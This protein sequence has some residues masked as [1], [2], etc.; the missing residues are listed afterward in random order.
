MSDA[1]ITLTDDN[2][3]TT[4]D[5]NDKDSAEISISGPSA[6]FAEGSDATFTVT[7]SVG[8]ASEVQVAWSAPLGTD[9]AEGA[10][11]SAT[12][13]T[14]TFAANSSAGATQSITITATD[15]AL[16][17]TVESFTVTLGTITST[18]SSQLSLKSG[19]SSATATISASDPITVSISGP[20]GE[21]T[22]GGAGTYTVSLS[23]VAPTADLTVSY[24]TADGTAISG[25]D[26]TAKSGTLTFTQTDAGDKT[27]TVRTIDDILAENSEDFTVSIS[28]PTG[29]GGPAPS[30]DTSK[31]TVTTTIRDNDALLLSPSDPSG[32]IDIQLS[33]API[34]VNEGAGETPFT[35]TATL[36]TGTPRTEDTTISLILGGTAGS[37]D[38]TAPAQ[39][40]VTISAN[41]PSG[42]GTLT[43]T[44]IDDD[45]SEGDETIIVGGS[46]GSLDIGSALT[47]IVDDDSTYLRITGPDSNVAEG[48]S[49][50]FTVTLSENVAADVT[51]AWSVVTGTAE[52]ADLG[53][54]T[55]GS[56]TFPADSGANA[57]Q[58]ITVAV[59]DDNLSEGSETFSVKLGADTGDQ[60]DN[61]W[62]RSTA[63]SATATIAESDPITVSITGTLTSVE[64]GDAVTYTVSISG[65]VPSADL[66]VDYA[67]SDGTAKATSD[68]T[69]KS[70]TLTFTAT[71][72]GSQTFTVQTTEDIRAEFSETFTVTISNPSGGGGPAPSLGTVKS[73]TT[74]I[75]DDDPTSDPPNNRPGA[76]GDVDVWLSVDP[77]SVNEN[78]GETSFTVTASHNSGT[79]PST[80]T[81]INLTLAGT[82]DESDYTAPAQAS[83]TIPGGQSSGS[84]PLTL[85]LIDDN[86]IEGDETIIV[87]GNL[88]SLDIGSALITINDDDSTYLS[89]SGPTSEVQEGGNASFTVTLSKTVSADVT[90]AW[91]VATDTA[92]TADLGATSGTVTFDANSAAG[93]TKTITVAVTDDALSEGAETFSVA[94]GDDTGDQADTVWV[95]STAASA[96]ATIAESDPITVNISGPSSVDEGDAATYTVSLLPSGVTPTAPLAVT[97][98]YTS[99]GDTATAGTDYTPA[100][101]SVTFTA[102]G[103]QTI[104]VQTTQDIVDESDETF[105]VTISSPS[106]GGGPAPNLGTASVTTTIT[107]DD[108]GGNPSPPLSAGAACGVPTDADGDTHT[109][110]DA[111]ARPDGDAHAYAESNAKANTRGDAHAYAESNAKAHAGGDPC[112]HAE[113]N[114]KAHAGGDAHAHAAS[115]A[116]A[117]AGGD[118]HAHAY[119][120]DGARTAPWNRVGERGHI[121]AWNGVHTGTGDGARAH[122]G[123]GANA[124]HGDD[125]RLSPACG[126]VDWRKR[127]DADR[128]SG[129]AD[130]PVV[131]AFSVGLVA[132]AVAGGA[133][134]NCDHGDEKT[135]EA[136]FAPGHNSV[137]RRA[138]SP[139]VLMR[140]AVL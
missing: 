26:Y 68:Y 72:A 83:V 114:A 102:A 56:V 139:Y 132:P 33:V 96:T 105:T 125:K 65:G 28:G 64:E 84:V 4:E 36:K 118:T 66:T 19:A 97:V 34:S 93:A 124:Q 47:T 53:A 20:T 50:S 108:T 111:H 51:V 75:D 128:R 9:S 45:V 94:L 16:S 21:V 135:A 82:A 70:G 115:N 103:S 52:T 69:A 134:S 13:G 55:S 136:C 30:L 131:V 91:S 121:G 140:R 81:T 38:Y 74:T 101:G 25:S 61:V 7:L 122:A 59:T 40:S 39:A 112:T 5:P 85:T 98:S 63:A 57:T 48:A 15:D 60:A 104:R 27:F 2:K 3:G 58:T 32:D 1:I 41:Q 31:T 100:P 89:I 8:V 44:L 17:E 6:A 130:H 78:A 109:D 76:M 86:D 10:D 18:L 73:V 37:S 116:K 95:K 137:L 49:A 12:S 126:P 23:G 117:H 67:T 43:L 99:D 11:L 90:V 87:G 110:G 113:S 54:T 29:G 14:V 22:E 123:R 106:G 88:G 62:V 107:D 80:A 138:E 46:S 127:F 119:A 133:D 35:V 120:R 79:P 77:E 42:S 71:A 92:E 129:A 24:A